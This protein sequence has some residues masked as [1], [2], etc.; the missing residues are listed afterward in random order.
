MQ[1]SYLCWVN[2]S[3]LTS[4]LR[5]KRL[6]MV[7]VSV[8]GS[9]LSGL[10]IVL[11]SSCWLGV[12]LKLRSD[13][14]DQHLILGQQLSK[15]KAHM[16]DTHRM[17]TTLHN[18][19][20]VHGSGSSALRKANP[21]IAWAAS[22]RDVKPIL[23]ECTMLAGCITSRDFRAAPRLGWASRAKCLPHQLLRCIRTM[24]LWQR[25]PG[26]NRCRLFHAA[27][28]VGVVV[29]SSETWD[30]R[31][32]RKAGRSPAAFE[33]LWLLPLVSWHQFGKPRL[34]MKKTG[35]RHPS[36][37]LSQQR[38]Y[39]LGILDRC[40]CADAWFRSRKPNANSVCSM[41]VSRSSMPTN[42]S[43]P[44]SGKVRRARSEAMQEGLS[45]FS[46]LHEDADHDVL[47]LGR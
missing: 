45:L 32:I 13:T 12:E 29:T 7:A 18:A 43:G 8:L 23:Q 42:L 36:S 30:Q 17:L 31:A 39:L 2:P 5:W 38:Q 41:C 47:D 3:E 27:M 33:W 35:G 24:V 26:C 1:D 44:V 28:G 4:L 10:W 37:E 40:C 11:V 20:T 46:F 15:F 14:A 25:R 9:I 34:R 22:L 21:P 16:E 19:C 6:G